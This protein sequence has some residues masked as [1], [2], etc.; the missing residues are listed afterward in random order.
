MSASAVVLPGWPS[1]AE[2]RPRK[3]GRFM[4]RVFVIAMVALAAVAL[5]AATAP[6]GQQSV[7]PQQFSALSKR[8]KALEKDDK[9]FKDF[10]AAV[11]ACVLDQGAIAT[12][13]APQYHITTVGETAD[14]YV[15][16]TNKQECVT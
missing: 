1:A 6:A 7:T 4:K 5:Y 2:S 13:K 12:T 8:V 3:K 14:F 16:T 9:N 11:L 10:A 15:L